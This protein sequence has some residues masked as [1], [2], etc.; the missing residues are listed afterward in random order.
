[1]ALGAL[2][3]A[4]GESPHSGNLYAALPLAGRTLLEYQARLAAAAGA[5]PIVVLVERMPPILLAAVDRLVG[6]GVAVQLA[7]ASDILLA[8][9]DTLLAAIKRRA[10][11][12]R[13]TPTIGRSHGI[14]AEPV[15]F[16][17]KLAGFYAEF[18][19]GRQRLEA[20]RKEIATCAISGAVGTFANI[21]PAVEEHV[22]RMMGLRPE[23][24]STQVSPGA[25]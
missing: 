22:C 8:D 23:P 14:H 17:L 2:I 9:I 21:D 19:R 24:I 20:A 13:M 16:G 11:E 1:M 18:E 15:T 12:H 25:M 6:E 7:R 4:Y 3:S 10:H 5:A